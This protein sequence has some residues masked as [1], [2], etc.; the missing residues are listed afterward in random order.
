MLEFLGNNIVPRRVALISRRQ[1]L[2]SWPAL[3]LL[4]ASEPQNVS[5]PLRGVLGTT[6]PEEFFFTRDHFPEPDLMLSTWRLKVEGRVSRPCELSFSDLLE[7][8]TRKIE[9]LLECAGNVASGFAVA[10]GVWEGVPMPDLLAEARPEPGATQVVLEGADIGSLFEGLS[11]FPYCQ[12]VPLQKCR[13]KDT[14]VAFKLNDRFLS[15]SRGF[16]ARALLPAWYGMDSV[17]WLQRILVVGPTDKPGSFR[18]S[19]MDRVYNRVFKA[20]NGSKTVMRV[21]E[22]QVKSVIAYPN[23]DAR[24]PVGVHTVWGFAWSG[25][26]V[27]R[28]VEV[29]IDGGSNWEPAHLESRP[30]PLTWVRWSYR[31]R[32]AQGEHTLLTRASDT[33]ARQQ[34]MRRD[35]ARADSY[36]LNWC[37]PLRCS[38]K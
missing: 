30:K 9:A 15:R 2:A 11:S 3:S 26:S 27:I 18:D 24:L 29:S 34:P 5:F 16:P 4:R 17:K 35:P 36:E 20:A 7:A 33:A 1:W 12:M 28:S 21:S 13:S 6:T 25:N 37:P 19:G 23:G 38:V 8:S 31:W 10:N 14:L 22:I 32:A